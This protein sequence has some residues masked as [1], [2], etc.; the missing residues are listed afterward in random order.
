VDFCG[1]LSEVHLPLPGGS[2]ATYRKVFVLSI[3]YCTH[4]AAALHYIGLYHS[5]LH[6]SVLARA[7]SYST[8]Y[9]QDRVPFQRSL[10]DVARCSAWWCT[11]VV[12]LH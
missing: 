5:L 6:D 4:F 2:S 9:T 8:L 12:C 10:L 1:N 7:M 3:D 11:E